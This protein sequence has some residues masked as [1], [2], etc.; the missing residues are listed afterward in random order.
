MIALAYPSR[1]SRSSA[2]ESGAGGGRAAKFSAARPRPANSRTTTNQVDCNR[3]PTAPLAGE[4][5][6][7]RLEPVARC[8]YQGAAA[9]WAGFKIDLR[10]RLSDDRAGLPEPPESP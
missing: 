7:E 2:L 8:N 5:F 10:M 9:V 6:A 3:N 1:A 4:P